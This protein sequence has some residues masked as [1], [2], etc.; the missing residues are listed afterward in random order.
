MPYTGYL[1]RRG[2]KRFILTDLRASF[3]VSFDRKPS[4]N[5]TLTP[6]RTVNSY[7]KIKQYKYILYEKQK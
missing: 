1:H 4:V 6:S 3:S 7:L 5:H 2:R